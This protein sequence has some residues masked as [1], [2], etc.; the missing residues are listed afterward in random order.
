MV[1]TEARADI[2]SIITLHR[3]IELHRDRRHLDDMTGLEV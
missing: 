3:K 2:D 1:D